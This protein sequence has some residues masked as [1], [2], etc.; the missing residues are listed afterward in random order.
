MSVPTIEVAARI[1]RR[2]IVNLTEANVFHNRSATERSDEISFEFIGNPLSTKLGLG[3]YQM[4]LDEAIYK[5][6]AK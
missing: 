1:N 6:I 4:I 3:L 5:N 2:A